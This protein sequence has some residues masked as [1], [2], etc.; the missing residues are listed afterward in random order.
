MSFPNLPAFGEEQYFEN[1]ENDHARV[2][3]FHNRSLQDYESYCHYFTEKNF[4]KI[5]ER[6]TEYQSY[7]AW[8]KEENGIFLN[9]FQNTEEL[10]IVLETNCSYFTYEDTCMTETVK[11]QISQIHLED[12]GMSYAIRLSDGRFVLIDGGREFET[13]ARRLYQCLKEG[14]PYEKPVIAA[15]IMTH[16]HE[17]HFY[18]FFP[19]MDNYKEDVIIEKFLFNFPNGDD[20]DHYPSLA[21]QN[22]QFENNAVIL[23][24]PKFLKY[25]TQTG[26][27][28]YMPHTGQQYKIGDAVFDILATMDD[29]IH[30]S[31]NINASSIVMRMCLAGQTILWTA[32]STFGH[33]HMPMR[34][35][36]SLKADILQVPH[37][38]FSSGDP[39]TEIE[40]YRLIRPDLCFLP[41]NQYNAYT[42]F[43][44]FRESSQ[45]LMTQMNVQEMIDGEI[46]RTITLPYTPRKNGAR[47][48]EINYRTGIA[49]AGARSWIFMDLHTEQKEDFE[50]TI[51]NTTHS[52][53]EIFIELFF[54]DPEKKVRFIKA[55]IPPNCIKRINIVDKKDIESET[56]LFNSMSLDKKGI[57][58][59]KDFSV[60]FIS[61]IPVVISNRKHTAAYHSTLNP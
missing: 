45:F 60:R 47:E 1:R 20:L 39:Q 5:E 57:P 31:K 36:A 58:K 4:K 56:L 61:N 55:T 16:P 19:F 28:V 2:M 17:D 48:L 33:T 8:K 41:V 23:M 9:F 22:A 40:G 44:P 53:A 54:D 15:W 37:H 50:Y 11:P 13:D 35:G 59:G 6:I 18:C 52:F 14:S 12:F 34:Y 49:N 10:S 30:C 42:A 25:V 21:V 51:L 3:M 24:M 29:T 46:T 27:K 43:V 32:D 26:A 38:G 7:S